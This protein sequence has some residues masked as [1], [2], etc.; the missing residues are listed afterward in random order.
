MVPRGWGHQQEAA[1]LP[2][3][4]VLCSLASGSSPCSAG[5]MTRSSL[6]QDAQCA[7]RNPR[8]SKRAASFFF[9]FFGATFST[10]FTKFGPQQLPP[11]TGSGRHRRDISVVLDGWWVRG[12]ASARRQGPRAAQAH[13]QPHCTRRQ[14]GVRGGSR[15]M[16][17]AR[18]LRATQTNA[19][20]KLTAPLAAAMPERRRPCAVPTNVATW[21]LHCQ[22]GHRPRP[23]RQPSGSAGRA[24]CTAAPG[25]ASPARVTGLTMVASTACCEPCHKASPLATTSMRRSS[26]TGTSIFMSAKRTLRATRAPASWHTRA[27]ALSRGSARDASTPDVAHAALWSPSGSRWPRQA[28]VRGATGSGSRSRRS[29]KMRRCAEGTVTSPDVGK[30]V[31]VRA[32]CG[33]A[34]DSSSARDAESRSE[35]CVSSA[36]WSLAVAASRCH[37]CKKSPNS[38]S[39]CCA[40]GR[41]KDPQAGGSNP[42]TRRQAAAWRA[43]RMGAAA[44]AEA[45]CAVCSAPSGSGCSAW[46]RNPAMHAASAAS[47]SAALWTI[48][49]QRG[50]S[51]STGDV[52]TSNTCKHESKCGTSNAS[53]PSSKTPSASGRSTMTATSLPL[54]TSAKHCACARALILTIRVFGIWCARLLVRTGCSLKFAQRM[55]KQDSSQGRHLSVECWG[56]W[57]HA[58]ALRTLETTSVESA[59]APPTAGAP[60]ST[61][62]V[63]AKQA[64]RER[65]GA[66]MLP[67]RGLVRRGHGTPREQTDESGCFS[68]PPA[69]NHDAKHRQV[70]AS[71]IDKLRVA[72]EIPVSMSP[73]R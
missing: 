19:Q 5:S 33:P 67:A 28:H 48:K 51:S 16:R 25:C 39:S 29:S 14:V 52:H 53:N 31:R 35:R 26:E 65:R 61:L 47:C 42:C 64:R 27:T 37:P 15:Q 68:A 46:S 69:T 6:H 45:S 57:D 58:P 40:G 20:P 66:C 38:R 71:G 55:H 34:C 32:A 59:R 70:A 73:F 72:F 23:R 21:R 50:P 49:S 41:C 44:S 4:Q 36:R 24:R 1:W 13:P 2:P 54:V 7:E 18:Q 3:R 62:L 10:C 12:A 30:T 56:R 9:F 43:A 8:P 17:A 60:P 22:S 63:P 11:P